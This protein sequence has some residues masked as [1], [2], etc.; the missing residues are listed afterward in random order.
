VKPETTLRFVAVGATA[1]CWASPRDVVLHS[2]SKFIIEM[3]IGVPTLKNSWRTK[4][5]IIIF[6]GV[7]YF[8]A[9]MA[10]N[11]ASPELSITSKSLILQ[12]ILVSL[13][14]GIVLFFGLDILADK[15]NKSVKP[16]LKDGEQVEAE[17]PASYKSNLEAIGGK[18]FLTNSYI[19]FKSHKYNFQSR[20]L[21]IPYSNIQKLKKSKS[22]SIIDNIL[23]INTRDKQACK[24][25]VN[26][27]DVWI[28]YINKKIRS[29]TSEDN[30][31]SGILDINNKT[32]KK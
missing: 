21:I 20:T 23:E 2:I 19:I 1:A 29:T 28:N 27:S 12:A 7:V 31:I 4:L 14:T 10:I 24:F 32:Q 6:G 16:D 30:P 26:E 11:A 25:I 15:L 5:P 18:I 3:K 9:Q 8:L 17:G 13:F 22:L